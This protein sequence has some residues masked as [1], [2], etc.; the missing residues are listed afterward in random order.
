MGVDMSNTEQTVEIL[1]FS[2]G[3]I[4]VEK[5]SKKCK[6]YNI[7]SVGDMAE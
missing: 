2:T 3:L 7:T 5:K 4:E 6:N 1:E